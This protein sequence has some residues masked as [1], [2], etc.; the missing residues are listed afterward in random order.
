MQ[1][2]PA[3]SEAGPLTPAPPGCAPWHRRGG[4]ARRAP[5]TGCAAPCRDAQLLE[6]AKAFG[7]AEQKLAIAGRQHHRAGN[8]AA[9]LGVKLVRNGLVAF[10]TERIA[11]MK[12]GEI[13]RRA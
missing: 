9:E 6:L 8:L 2:I 11:G 5:P 13:A 4:R 1:A 7:D 10:G 3:A 12:A